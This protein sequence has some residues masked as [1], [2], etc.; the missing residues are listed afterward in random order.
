MRLFV[1][2]DLPPSLRAG[3]DRL[4]RRLREGEPGWRWVRPASIHLTL[5]FLGEVD[6][7]R[8]AASHVAWQAAAATAEPF[9]VDVGGVGCF[10]PRGQPRVL[11]VGIDD[12]DGRL[13][14]LAGA[15]DAGAVEAGFQPE[16]RPFRGHLTLARAARDGRPPRPEVDADATAP[17]P[18]DELVLFRSELLPT[19]ARYT[20]LARFPLGRG[21]AT[22]R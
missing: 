2:V 5:R 14:R 7:Q 13:A 22:E 11:W 6:E 17:L 3:L 4:Q 12:A 20:A 10:P 16:R 9:V 21:G 19:G 18:V 1:A 15:V 8:A